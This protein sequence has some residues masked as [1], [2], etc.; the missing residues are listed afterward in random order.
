MT[1]SV[2][3]PMTDWPAFSGAAGWVAVCTEMQKYLSG[4][5]AEENWAVGQALNLPLEPGRYDPTVQWVYLSVDATKPDKV[6]QAAPILRDPPKGKEPFTLPLDSTDG[7]RLNFTQTARPGAYLFTLTWKKREGEPGPETKPE[8]L[9]AV[10]NIDAA[11]E[12]DLRRSNSDD[13]KTIAKGAEVHSPDD[14][15]WLDTL[16][17]KQTD[18]SSGRWLY[19]VI[20]LVLIAEQAMAVR[21]SHHGRP[22]DLEAFAPSA[23]AAFAR[24]STLTGK[25]MGTLSSPEPATTSV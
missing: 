16:K 21:L 24:G 6:T 22:E 10:F 4:G 1:T 20:L 3:D 19:L 5:G 12:G 23:A 8:Y 2:G 18:L 25:A 7:D 14:T 11:R 17:Q 9:A 15:T 13:L